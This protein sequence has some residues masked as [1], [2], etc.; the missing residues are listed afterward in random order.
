MPSSP[1]AA[2]SAVP[3]AAGL[4]SVLDQ[5]VD[6][7]DRRGVR[8]GLVGV[9]AAGIAA[10]VAG[11]RSFA[12]IAEWLADQEASVTA[13]LGRADRLP[14]ESTIRRLFARLDPDL[15]DAVVGAWFWTATR[16]VNGRRVITIDGKTV[17]GARAA[18]AA[19]PHLVAAFDHAACVVL[20]QVAVAAKTNEIPTVRTLLKVLD[21]A[22]AVLTLDAMHT[23]TDT[24]RA[25]TAPAA[26]TCSP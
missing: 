2:V 22:G 8:H 18:G 24:A 20:G 3:N 15:L 10:T 26:T 21:L 25:I 17:R 13:S 9:L 11:A 14:V 6:P 7:R 12:A 16:L 4:L 1:T 19:A 23:Q 5:V